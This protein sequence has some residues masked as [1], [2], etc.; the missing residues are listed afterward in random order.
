MKML[1][2]S[3]IFSFNLS[4]W[5]GIEIFRFNS[6][7]SLIKCYFSHG[8]RIYFICEDFRFPEHG[9]KIISV[10]DLWPIKLLKVWKKKRANMQWYSGEVAVNS[11]SG[12]LEFDKCVLEFY[13]IFQS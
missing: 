5:S 12:P 2:S 4:I 10:H 1:M 13:K 9:S 6:Q 11:S 3:W 8:H 7:V